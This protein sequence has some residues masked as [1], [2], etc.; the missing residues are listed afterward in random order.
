MAE[1]QKLT[2]YYGLRRITSI[3]KKLPAIASDIRKYASKK[4]DSDDVIKD[5]AKHVQSLQQKYLDLLKERTKIRLA[6]KIANLKTFITYKGRKMCLDEA[7]DWKGLRHIKGGGKEFERML[8]NSF[9]TATADAEIG[10]IRVM[11]ENAGAKAE[12]ITASK[13]VPELLGWDALEVAEKKELLGEMEEEIDALITQANIETVL[14][15]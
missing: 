6:I 7:I 2:I 8:W 5:Q 3:E 11:L 4:K 13:F 12:E 15:L 9:T 10:R 1:E 14:K